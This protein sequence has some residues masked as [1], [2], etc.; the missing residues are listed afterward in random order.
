MEALARMVAHQRIQVLS[1]V[2]S[3]LRVILDT[4]ENLSGMR[5]LED[6]L[7]GGEAV[8][9][10]LALRARELLGC[11]V[12][13]L[14]GPTE[15]AMDVTWVEFTPE[16]AVEPHRSSRGQRHGSCPGAGGCRGAGRGARGTLSRRCSGGRWVLES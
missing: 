11:R 9:G 10:N 8:P 15:A 16:L 1:L 14:Y 7:L 2:P 4:V 6:L 12:H 5:C 13:S 3:H